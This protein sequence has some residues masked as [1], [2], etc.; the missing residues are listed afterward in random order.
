[1]DSP[2]GFLT[3]IIDREII[4]IPAWGNKVGGLNGDERGILLGDAN[5]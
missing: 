1:L 5:L 3:I 4:D 2:Y